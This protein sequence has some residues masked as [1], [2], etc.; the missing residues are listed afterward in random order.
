MGI[1]SLVKFIQ[2]EVAIINREHQVCA[3]IGFCWLWTL[4]SIESI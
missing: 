4:S 2:F 3:F 1:G